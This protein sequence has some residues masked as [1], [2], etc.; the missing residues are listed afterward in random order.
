MQLGVLSTSRCRTLALFRPAR[1]V[2]TFGLNKQPAADLAGLN[3]VYA[4]V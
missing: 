3:T 2:L 4:A 1:A